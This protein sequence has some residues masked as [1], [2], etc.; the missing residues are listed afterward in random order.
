M[1]GWLI[2]V[3]LACSA[4]AQSPTAAETARVWMPVWSDLER[5]EKLPRES[6]E[7]RALR[8][9]LRRTALRREGGA[10]DSSDRALAYRARVLAA[11]LSALDG[12]TLRVVK[13][14]EARIELL[15]IETWRAARATLPGPMRTFATAQALD[16]AGSAELDERAEFARAAVEED[17]A[18]C[19]RFDLAERLAREL[20]VRVESAPNAVL[21]ARTLRAN[22]RYE[23]AGEL[24]QHVLD[25]R[26]GGAERRLL[27]EE[28]ARVEL[29][30]GSDELALDA[31]GTALASDSLFA[32]VELARRAARVGEPAR[33]LALSRP[34]LEDAGPPPSIVRAWGGTLLETGAPPARSAGR[35]PVRSSPHAFAPN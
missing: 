20:L 10:H 22:G 27:A 23:E 26:T 12:G 35:A 8:D 13:D 3:G 33:A 30:R 32:T 5:L 6:P 31:L 19:Q 24:L 11:H 17:L 16:E 7:W 4:Q 34:F 9:G 2:A 21:C 25:A 15:P 28:L 29:A 1:A 14:P 18:S